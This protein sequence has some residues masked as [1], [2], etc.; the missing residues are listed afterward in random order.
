MVGY[1]ISPTLDPILPWLSKQD[2]DQFFGQVRPEVYSTPF[3]SYILLLPPPSHYHQFTHT[4]S[5]FLDSDS[6]C[7]GQI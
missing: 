1:K 4:M 5:L 6:Y 7:I 2:K 3:A